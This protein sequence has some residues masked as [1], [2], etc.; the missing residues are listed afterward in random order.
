M[1]VRCT[2]NN[3]WNVK[4]Y[5]NVTFYIYNNGLC[6][7]TIACCDKNQIR[8]AKKKKIRSLPISYVSRQQ[9]YIYKC[10]KFHSAL[11]LTRIILNVY[12]HWS[13]RVHWWH[14][15]GYFHFVKKIKEI[16]S[17]YWWNK[18]IIGRIIHRQRRTTQLMIKCKS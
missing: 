5:I 8:K 3:D 10:N 4:L 1:H 11:I 16:G 2:F 15:A 17:I 7:G 9:Y 13:S 12:L 18:I 6:Y 14:F